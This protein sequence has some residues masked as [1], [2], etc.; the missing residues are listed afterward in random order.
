MSY[1]ESMFRK[2]PVGRVLTFLWKIS[3]H[4]ECLVENPDTGEFANMGTLNKGCWRWEM[5]CALRAADSPYRVVGK[6]RLHTFN[7]ESIE[8]LVDRLNAKGSNKAKTL[9]HA[10]PSEIRPIGSEQIVYSSEQRKYVIT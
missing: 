6:L 2:A 4:G 1:F 10:V 8:E 9:F 3:H 7:V 5:N